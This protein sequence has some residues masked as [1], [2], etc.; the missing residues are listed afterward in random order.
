MQY[1]VDS[2]YQ[3]INWNAKGDEQIVQNVCNILNLIKNEVPYARDKG[4]DLSNIDKTSNLTRYKLIEETYDL[5]EKYEP[6]VI[7]DDVQVDFSSNPNIK[8][9]ITID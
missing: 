2:N 7:V 8:V 5:I 4:R 6:R 3:E 9:V 1:T